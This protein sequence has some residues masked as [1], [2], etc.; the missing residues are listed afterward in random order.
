MQV[1]FCE[2][3]CIYKPVVVQ[4]E[5]LVQCLCV[6]TITFVLNDLWPKYL[7]CWFILTLSRSASKVNV[8]GQSSWSHDEGCSFFSCGLMLLWMYIIICCIY[9]F[10]NASGWCGLDWELSKSRAVI[11]NSLLVL[12]LV[13]CVFWTWWV[14]SAV[15]SLCGNPTPHSCLFQERKLNSCYVRFSF[16]VLSQEIGWEECLR[17][18]LFCVRWGVKPSIIQLMGV[19]GHSSVHFNSLLSDIRSIH[20][21]K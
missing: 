14:S 2:C 5:Q 7:A 11:R 1:Y 18:D 20:T 19:V 13:L 4:V 3:F 6:W 15:D 10:L 8:R 16:S 9:Q 12:G 21:F 17:N